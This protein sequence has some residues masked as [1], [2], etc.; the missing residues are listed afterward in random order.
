[1]FHFNIQFSSFLSSRDRFYTS[2]LLAFTQRTLLFRIRLR[3][4]SHPFHVLVNAYL[5]CVV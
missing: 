5:V 2:C 3:R 1:M 4:I